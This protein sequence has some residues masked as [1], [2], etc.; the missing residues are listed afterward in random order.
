M[1]W[2]VGLSFC[3]LMYLSWCFEVYVKMQNYDENSALCL[4]HT[5]ETVNLYAAGVLY[6]S[7]LTS[8]GRLLDLYKQSPRNEGHFILVYL[9]TLY[10]VKNRG[11]SYAE[12]IVRDCNDTY[13]TGK[14]R[15]FPEILFLA[16]KMHTLK[17]QYRGTGYRVCAI[18]SFSVE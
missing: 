13:I 10:F 3:N 14:H 16:T 18:Y 11:M 8:S 12:M 5:R 15:G 9:L 4:L 6:K 2:I 7:K 17:S 1:D